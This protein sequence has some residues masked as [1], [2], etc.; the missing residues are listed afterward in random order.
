MEASAP[1]A[2]VWSGGRRAWFV[3][4]TVVDPSVHLATAEAVQHCY[5]NIVLAML[6]SGKVLDCSQDR[7]KHV[8]GLAT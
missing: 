7:K 8:A 6:P 5:S 2:F 1:T 4:G 3:S